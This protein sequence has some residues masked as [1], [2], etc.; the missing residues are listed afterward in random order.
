VDITGKDYSMNANHGIVRNF[1]PLTGVQT[2][3]NTGVGLNLSPEKFLPIQFNYTE[4]KA[5]VDPI[6]STNKNWSMSTGLDLE[7]LH[8]TSGLLRQESG[9]NQT[10]RISENQGAFA[11][12]EATFN[13]WNDTFFHSGYDL[14]K[15]QSQSMDIENRT[16]S[17]S[18]S[19][20]FDSTL[21]P[22]LNLSGSHIRD[23]TSGTS[24]SGLRS[25]TL[26][27]EQE[28]SDVTVQVAPADGWALSLH[29]GK[30]RIDEEGKSRIS[31]LTAYALTASRDVT[32]DIDGAFSLSHSINDDSEQG[33]IIS[34]SFFV[35]SNMILNPSIT[36]RINTGVTRSEI[37]EQT[38]TP[39]TLTGRYATSTNLD[40]WTALTARAA[41]AVNY[42][43]GSIHNRLAF[44]GRDN[45]SVGS[46]LSYIPKPNVIYSFS[47]FRSFPMEGGARTSFNGSLSYG[48]YKRSR[49]T[50]SY[51]KSGG[52]EAI[53]DSLSGNFIFMLGKQVNILLNYNLSGLSSD[54]KTKSM[55]IQF[56]KPF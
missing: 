15:N 45:Q 37:P 30:S 16:E 27:S 17:G 33:K 56:S 41:F 5:I 19:L 40:L 42:S 9:T 50:L 54:E 21:Y 3:R 53:S 1:D 35:T 48:F 44:F 51:Q 22:W 43:A 38:L 28:I 24:S 26:S 36:L 7:P 18:F 8:L 23:D 31:D 46:T 20:L 34:N 4:N 14:S 39:S 47:A 11:G 49:M 13:L 29:K 10:G 12:A 55:G 25:L 6:T 2:S 32:P 52:E